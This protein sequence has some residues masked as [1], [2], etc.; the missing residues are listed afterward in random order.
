MFDNGLSQIK[1]NPRQI[2]SQ[3]FNI[4]NDLNCN[5]PN[6][7]IQYLMNSGQISQGMLNQKYNQASQMAKMF[8]R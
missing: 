6:E 1:Q 7:V 2:I 3:R 8:K 4:P 5:N